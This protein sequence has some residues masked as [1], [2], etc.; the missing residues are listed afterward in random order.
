[1]PLPK[2]IALAQALAPLCRHH[3]AHHP[4]VQAL[5][6]VGD[7]EGGPLDVAERAP[8]PALGAPVAV[9]LVA[10]SLDEAQELAVGDLRSRW[11]P[12]WTDQ[13]AG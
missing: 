6:A 9:V 12:Q 13:R 7:P 8:A 11:R 4:L 5:G 2:L 1:M 3:C 10:A